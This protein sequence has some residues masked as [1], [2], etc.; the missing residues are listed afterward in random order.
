[1]ATKAASTKRCKKTRRV[2][3]NVRVNQGQHLHYFITVSGQRGV[4]ALSCRH[5]THFDASQ[6]GPPKK[7]YDVVWP[8]SS[9]D[10][11]AGQDGEDY[12]FT[13]SF[14]S[15]LKYTLRVEL[16]DSSHTVVDNGLIVDADYEVGS[17]ATFPCNESFV[18]RTKPQGA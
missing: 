14:V 8:R 10:E 4:F 12:T 16:H 11:E 15:A 2:L 17:D 3:R 13:M 18:V 6:L 5:K 9:A 1:M 7:N